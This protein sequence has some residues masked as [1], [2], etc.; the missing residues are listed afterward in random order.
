MGCQPKD[1]A[2][3]RGCQKRGAGV[4]KIAID[5]AVVFSSELDERLLLIDDALSRL[6]GVERQ[7]GMGRAAF[8]RRLDL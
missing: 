8:L 7:A 3:L 6:A 5:E 2:R 1:H 4:E